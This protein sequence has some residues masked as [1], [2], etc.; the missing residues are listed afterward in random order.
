MTNYFQAVGQFTRGFLRD[1][2]GAQVIEYAL[3]I[4]VVSIAL[5]VA[6]KASH[7]QQRQFH[8][9]HR[10]GGPVPRRVAPA[11]KQLES[12]GGQGLSVFRCSPLSFSTQK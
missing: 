9:L 2:D 10:D 7:R 11:R 8:D 4:A 3:I 1:D 12:G 6:L 5:V